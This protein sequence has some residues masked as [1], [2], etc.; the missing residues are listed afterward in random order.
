VRA[1]R[2]TV[3][4]LGPTAAVLR[5][6]TAALRPL[7]AQVRRLSEPLR[8]QLRALQPVIDAAIPVTLRLPGV[9]D[10]LGPV[11][12]ELRANGPEVVNFFTL[13]GDATSNYDANGNLIRTMAVLTQFERHPEVIPTNSN[14]AGS[15]ARPFYR[16]PGTAEGEPWDEYWKSFIAGAKRPEHFLTPEELV[17]EESP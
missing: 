9:L 10:M 4:E 17:P 16:T 7:V 5:P 1:A 2:P 15:I 3:A 12:D 8:A 13:F 14:E 6:A 11:L